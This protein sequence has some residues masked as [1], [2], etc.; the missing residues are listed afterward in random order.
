MGFCSLDADYVREGY[1][2]VDNVFLAK[3]L[4]EADPVDV[5][6]Y[7]YG[8]ML[9]L[10][11]RGQDNTKDAVSLA[12]RLTAE[13]VSAAF[14]YWA[15]LGLVTVTADGNGVVYNSVKAPT[16]KAVYYNAREYSEF[17][18]ELRRVF[19]EKIIPEQD[20]MRY[21]E[22]L[23]VYKMEQ[24]AMLLIARYCRD[25]KGTTNTASVVGLAAAWAK[26]GLTTERAVNARLDELERNSEEMKNVYSAL[27]LRSEPSVEDAQLYVSWQDKGFKPDAIMVACRA[28]KRKGGM[29]RLVRL[30][31]E[32]YS[33]KALTAEE[34]NEYL[35]KKDETRA[36]AEQ[37]IRTI[38]SFYATLDMPVE[39]YINPWL[40]SGFEK[41]A[42]L[43]IAKFCFMR[44]VRTLDG[45]QVYVDK[46]YK[47]GVVTAQGIDAYVQR[48]A[49]IDNAI[50]EVLARCGAEPFITMRDRDF[51]R[52]F[53]EDW[54][55][56]RE[57]IL[58][59]ADYA[60]SK[61]FPMSYI[62][63]ILLVMKENG[64]STPEGARKLLDGGVSERKKD[65]DKDKIIKQNYTAE[66]VA[67]AFIG[68]DDINP[69]DVDI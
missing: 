58:A 31:D 21:V 26:Q 66:E 5:K 37:I 27:G 38:G 13:R 8:L 44:N 51:Y 11:G 57:T 32:L 61:P 49:A 60:K 23:R 42:L 35:R 3:Y 69:D 15:E 16:T 28:C 4:P 54:G 41:E 19:P 17:V 62:N 53:M 52:T 1:T 7:L 18:D 6:V 67:S 14:A 36:F 68:L 39:T 30:M 43:A 64:I 63:K 29:Q 55:F 47:L 40:A 2:Q 34:A 59:V 10:G 45:M 50:K 65:A 24:N 46:F 56:D 48:Q 12:L 9:A 25:A 22:T 20:V 33:V